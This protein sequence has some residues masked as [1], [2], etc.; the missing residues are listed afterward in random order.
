MAS[1]DSTASSRYLK[2]SLFNLPNAE[3]VTPLRIAEVVTPLRIA[4]QVVFIADRI[5]KLVHHLPMALRGSHMQ[6]GLVANVLHPEKPSSH[7]SILT[8]VEEQLHDLALA[9]EG[10]QM[11]SCLG[12]DVPHPDA[13]LPRI[14]VR[15]RVE[16]PIHDQAMA[17][18]AAT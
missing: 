5:G 10:G 1:L 14:V 18:T 17:H 9:S 3:V 8:R 13:S 16:E 6:R 2:K 11:Q 12:V 15:A 4:C 7:V